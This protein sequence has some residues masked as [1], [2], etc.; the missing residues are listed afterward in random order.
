MAFKLDCFVTVHARNMNETL[1]ERETVKASPCCLVKFNIRPHSSPCARLIDIPSLATP[2][3]EH[4][5]LHS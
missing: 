3:W 5:D 1:D 4:P 2:Q